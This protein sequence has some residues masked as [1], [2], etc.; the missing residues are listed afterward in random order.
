VDFR[1][2]VKPISRAHFANALSWHSTLE[3]A[4]AVTAPDVGS[5]GTVTGGVTFVAGRYGNAGSF[6]ATGD[7]VTAPFANFNIAIGTV[8]LWYRPNYDCQ[9]A[10][11]TCDGVRHTLWIMEGDA[12]HS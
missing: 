11:L 2:D 8:E 3:S 10:P 1:A 7:Y 5:G 4:G 12:T 6:T 9:S